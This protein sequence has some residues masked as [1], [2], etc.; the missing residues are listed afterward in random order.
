MLNK[1][2]V[3][4]L[5]ELGR[6]QVVIKAENGG[7]YTPERLVRITQPIADPV[8]VH[9]LTAIV[10]YIKENVDAL[11]KVVIS[12]QSPTTVKVLSPLNTDK[13]REVYLEAKALTPSGINFD[14]F[15]T[16]DQFNI[17]M[18]AGFVNHQVE[19]LDYKNMLLQV[20]GLVRE[21]AVKE[22]GDDGV[23]QAATIKTGVASVGEVK[24][25]NPVYLAPYRTFAE[26]EQPVSKFVFRMETG[27]KAALFEADGGAWKNEAI[28]KIR[29]YLKEQLPDFERVYILA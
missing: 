13:N 23:S 3:E 26:I 9:T 1:D 5:V 15:M 21:Q 12:V 16:T 29:D 6:E 19:G 17:M 22:I 11:G 4:Y 27:P 28:L 14:R 8:P 18:Q 7:E 2:A 24:V 10:D 20:T 25:P